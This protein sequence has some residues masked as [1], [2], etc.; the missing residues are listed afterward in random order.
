MHS[1]LCTFI[2]PTPWSCTHE[3]V[4]PDSIKF[5]RVYCVSVY[6]CCSTLSCSIQQL[7]QAIHWQE[8]NKATVR[9]E[10]LSAKQSDIPYATH[11][12]R[13]TMQ[14]SA[15]RC[16][17]RSRRPLCAIT[18]LRVG[19]DCWSGLH[20]RVQNVTVGTNSRK[21]KFELW[22]GFWAGCTICSGS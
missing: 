17:A 7:H 19:S 3:T 6:R 4:R 9:L 13:H 14:H 10:L 15:T 20:E 1:Y 8:P 12:I 22:V 18:A 2:L 5:V 16:L 11:T 21:R